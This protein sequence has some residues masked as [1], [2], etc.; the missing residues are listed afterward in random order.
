MLE[1]VA[2][3]TW[4]RPKPVLA[5]VVAFVVVAGVFGH[6]VEHHLKAAGFTDSASESEQATELLRDALGYDATP[7]IVLLVRARDHGRLDIRQPRG[8]A[9]GGPPGPRAAP[10]RARGQG[11]Q[12]A[13]RPARGA[14]ADRPRRRARWC[15]RATCRRRTSRTRAATRP[16]RRSGGWRRAPS[17]CAW[18]ASRP[19]FNEVNDQTREDL[20]KAELIAFPILAVLLL[21]V[22][23]GVVAAAIPLLIGVFSILGTFLMLR[24]DV[25]VRGHVAVRAEHRHGAEPRPGR[26]LRAAAGL[27]LPR[28]DRRRRGHPRGAPQDGA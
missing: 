15:S 2:D 8:Q 26:R 10:H 25:G 3:L 18:A 14:G 13:A 5:V 27:A 28:G 9:R 1:R 7:G 12:P 19:R 20:T 6:D 4:K 23:R 24:A 17:T 22:F 21:L 11:R 16:R